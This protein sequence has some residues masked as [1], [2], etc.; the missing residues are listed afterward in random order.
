MIHLYIINN[1]CNMEDEF[2]KFLFSMINETLLSIQF[3]N[4]Y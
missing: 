1:M 3:I 2:I 4:R